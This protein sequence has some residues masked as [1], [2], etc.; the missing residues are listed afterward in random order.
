MQKGTYDPFL[1]SLS[2]RAT[3]GRPLKPYPSAPNPLPHPRRRRR[4]PL[5]E[6]HGAD[7]GDRASLAA[8]WVSRRVT[9]AGIGGS[10]P[11]LR[12][13]PGNGGACGLFLGNGGAWRAAAALGERWWMSAVL[14]LS[15]KLRPCSLLGRLS[16]FVALVGWCLGRSCCGGARASTARRCRERTRARSGPV[17]PIW[18]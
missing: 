6:A 15:K 1:A 7:G 14:S 4:K 18:V 17:G 9:Q 8:F 12:L 11:A 13:S 2:P 3:Q 16:S 10:L 5:R